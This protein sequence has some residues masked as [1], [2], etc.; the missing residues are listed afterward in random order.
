MSTASTQIAIT[1]P[2]SST[3]YLNPPV[4]NVGFESRPTTSSLCHQS[5]TLFSVRSRSCSA[6]S[7]VIQPVVVGGVEKHKDACYISDGPVT[8]YAEAGDRELC[9]DRATCDTNYM[10]SLCLQFL[11]AQLSSNDRELC[12]APLLMG[13][14]PTCGLQYY[15]HLSTEGN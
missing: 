12:C 5:Q 10:V 4:E 14:Q 13:H 8:E 11:A 2:P 3:E 6:P 9:R 1:P 15:Y 7:H